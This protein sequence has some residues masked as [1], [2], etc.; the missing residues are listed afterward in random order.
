MRENPTVSQA[1]GTARGSAD[2]EDGLR[3]AIAVARLAA[4]LKTADV[5]VLDLRGLSALTD[6]FVIG[7][8][9][10]DRQARAVLDA[11]EEHARSVGRRPF[12]TTDRAHT[13]WLLADYIDVVVHIFDEEHRAYYDLD[14][15]WGD[16]P[17]VEWQAQPPE[18]G[19]PDA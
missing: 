9:T 10:S 11:I 16:A 17:R 14:G 13:S 3:F 19:T 15:L 8:G 18:A 2:S 7:T 6:F 12:S 1:G 4:D 5:A